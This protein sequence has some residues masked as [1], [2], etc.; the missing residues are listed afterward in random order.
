V[1]L[2]QGLNAMQGK[3]V[4]KHSLAEDA[5]YVEREL[6]GESGG[7]QDQ[8]AVSY[9]GF[10]RIDFD[11]SGF[12]VRPVI[13]A[14]ERKQQLNENLMMLFTGVSRFSSKVA[15]SQYAATKDNTIELLE[16]QNLVNDAERI[17]ISGT[18]INEFGRLLDYS[19]SLKRG[20][21]SNISTDLID[22]IYKIAKEN[23]AI[24]GKLL[25]AGGG[26]FMIF[27]ADPTAQ[28]KI[29]AT[30]SDFIHIPFLFENEGS[31]IFHY[32]PEMITRGE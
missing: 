2:L 21:T 16:M 31:K 1:G 30:L 22:N 29:R 24:G 6:C 17:L 10:N 15:V 25:G 9:G 26:G 3:Y 32:T 7:W 13:I 23:G 27:F 19:W 12:S 18:D 28:M 11:L 20:L 14:S 4:D 8:V 5:I